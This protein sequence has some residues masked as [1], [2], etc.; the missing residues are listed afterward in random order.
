MSISTLP[1]D[2]FVMSDAD[3]QVVVV[4]GHIV[5]LDSNPVDSVRGAESA[6]RP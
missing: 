5:L 3:R 1:D 6:A 2:E 4:N